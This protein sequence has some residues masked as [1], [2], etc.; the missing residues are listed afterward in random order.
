MSNDTPATGHARID[1]PDLD[2]ALAE[3]SPP[4]VVDVRLPSEWQDGHVPGSLNLPLQD[5]EGGL[6]G[7]ERDE[8]IVVHCQS[9]YRSSIAASL[10]ERHGFS[11]LEDLRG[12]WQAWQQAHAGTRG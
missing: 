12:G 2:R 6:A 4:R 11:R 7:L 5:L 3:R 1:A 10:L 8:R 9:G